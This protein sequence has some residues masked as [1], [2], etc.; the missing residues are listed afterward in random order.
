MKCKRK[1]SDIFLYVSRRTIASAFL[2]S[3]S[4]SLSYFF[5]SL[6]FI[7]KRVRISSSYFH[8]ACSYGFSLVTTKVD[9]IQAHKRSTYMRSK[10]NTKDIG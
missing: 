3:F 7:I 6:Y 5:F 9:F 4:Y 1:V 2:S 10:L 8:C